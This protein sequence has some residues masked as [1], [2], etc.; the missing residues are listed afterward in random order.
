MSRGQGNRVSRARRARAPWVRD[1]LI[2]V[3]ALYMDAGKRQLP[4]TNLKVIK[5]SD[6]IGRSPD[7]VNMRMGNFYAVDPDYRGD[8][9][10]AGYDKCKA[11][12]DEFSHA[13][14]HLRRAAMSIRSSGP[15]RSGR[16]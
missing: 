1:E 10:R 12:W 9:L 5:L 3:L 15:F 4:V 7:A 2:L 11:I 13:P 6:Y 14:T 16:N 8:G